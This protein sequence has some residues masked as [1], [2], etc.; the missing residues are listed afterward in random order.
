MK[1]RRDKISIYDRS[2]LIIIREEYPQ[3]TFYYINLNLRPGGNAHQAFKNLSA[4]IESN[5]LEVLIGFAFGPDNHFFNGSANSL[6][7]LIFLKHDISSAYKCQL[8]CTESSEVRL[9]QENEKCLVKAVDHFGS[10]L[11]FISNI[12]S[13]ESDSCYTQ[14]YS[15][16]KSLGKILK[17]SRISYNNLVRTW[18][19]L[20]NILNWYDDL[21]KARTDFYME[22]NIFNGFIPASTGVGLSN[23]YGRCLSISAFALLE[24]EGNSL[25]RLINSPMQCDATNYKSSFSRAVEITHKTSKRLIISG[26]A[27]IGSKGE[28][29]YKG[30]IEKQIEH[31]M[32]VVSSIM[33]NEKYEWENVVRAIAYF[34]DPVDEKYFSEYCLRNHIDDSCILTVGGTICRGDLL[35][36]IEL[37]AV[38]ALHS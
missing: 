8:I 12:L 18:L 25:I 9:I 7:S 30:S 28:T 20:Q 27:S 34:L 38:K 10:S 2:D 5:G 26:T 6:A 32:E 21:N 22:E 35:F 23:I 16:F 1:I 37:D 3:H 11:V 14:A 33:F 13:D 24:N 31:T 15:S 29:L 36:E 17:D 19:Y 4:Y